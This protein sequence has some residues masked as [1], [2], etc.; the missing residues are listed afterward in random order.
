MENE[1]KKIDY[2]SRAELFQHGNDIKKEMSKKVDKVETKVDKISEEVVELKVLVIP[3][4]SSSKETAKNTQK[5][6]DT[7][8][9]Y[10][11]ATTKQLHDHDLQIADVK[12]SIDYTLKSINDDGTEE[13]EKRFS[14]VQI[15]TSVL[16]LVGIILGAILNWDWGHFI[17]K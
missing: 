3:M 15:I 5:M 14:N 13:K 8:E 1:K 6:A 2:V 16:A 4:V 12:N 7:L 11:Q 17:F 9:R 10:T